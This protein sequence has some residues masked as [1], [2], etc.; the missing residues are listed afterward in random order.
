MLKFSTEVKYIKG[1]G[2]KRASLLNTSNIYTV[3][4][5]LYYLPFRYEDRRNFMPIEALN[6]D[7]VATITGKILYFGLKPTRRKGFTIFQMVIDDGTSAL[8]VLWFNQPYLSEVFQEGQKVVLY[9]TVQYDPYGKTHLQMANPDYE[10]IES[11]D[12][13]S[14]HMN[15]I[16]PIYRR[17]GNLS[18]KMLR[19]IMFQLLNKLVPVEEI[20]PQEIY[21]RQD[22]IPISDAF[23]QIHFPSED[24]SL[25]ALNNFY[26][27]AHKR[28][29]FQEFLMLQVGLAL[30]KKGIQKQRGIQ[31][32]TSESLREKLKALLPFSLTHA[33]RR[34]FKEIVND[35]RSPYPM[36][37]L[38]QGDVG[39]GKTI[40]AMLTMLI[41][42]ENGFQ[43][44]LMAPTEILVEQ[45]FATISRLLKDSNYRIALL[46]RGIKG[47]LKQQILKNIEK[48][49]IDL[50]IGT[51]A[52]IQEG[53]TFANL[54]LAVIDEQHR[55]GVL[56]RSDL[57][58]KGLKPDVLVMSATPIPR[59]LALT[60]YGDLDLSIIDELP[61]GR[62]PI[63]TIFKTDDKRHEV[64]QFIRKQIN[65]GRQIYIVYP[66]IEETEKS[67]LKAAVEGAERLHKEILP[68]YKT[69]LLHGRMSSQ[70]KEEVMRCFAA[71]EIQL[72]VATTVIEVGIDVP[73]ANVMVIEHSERYGLSQLHQLRGRVG[74]GKHKSYCILLAQVPKSIEARRIARKRLNV[75]KES[76]DGFYIA[77]KDLEF[78]GPGEFF[79]T[80]QSGLPGLRVGNIIRDRKL[81]EE[82]RSEAF[83]LIGTKEGKA[84]NK[85]Q[86]I[87][88]Y[89]RNHW[90]KKFSLMLIG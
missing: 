12:V 13:D 21:H 63:T 86:M 78:R 17:I 50:I 25:D 71:G 74:R 14:I 1:V 28:L 52:L 15:R 18:S 77:E 48:G 81:M 22:L 57:V 29:I 83:W 66:L 42:V 19:K 80:R 85:Q 82:A 26:S 87:I 70:D 40:I 56:Q 76:N 39:S 36:N 69:G 79:G 55:F 23:H 65:K 27:L 84:S 24:E 73:N 61:P 41:A 7:Q 33:Q 16:V 60:V 47:K 59:S 5:L 3:E 2:P 58:Q 75:L 64:Y 88:R 37:R 6:P 20:L 89:V 62:Q 4:D 90:D 68:E 34:I 30:R 53:V 31:F 72:L 49:E 32:K 44:A 8:K 45:H 54:G 35:M 51:H 11:E 43:A 67:D 46:S 10:I 9:G 38:L